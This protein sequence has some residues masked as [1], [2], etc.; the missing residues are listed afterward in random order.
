MSFVIVGLGG[1]VSALLTKMLGGGV[2]ESFL[3]PLYG[4]QIVM[5]GIVV[6]SAY[7]IHDEIKVLRNDI[8]KLKE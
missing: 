7:I 1:L 2:A 3:Y 6:A 8:N 4:G 5:A